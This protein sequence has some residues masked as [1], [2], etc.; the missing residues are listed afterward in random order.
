MFDKTTKYFTA[1]VKEMCTDF[2]NEL[3]TEDKNK[4][5]AFRHDGPYLATKK[6]GKH[7]P[8]EAEIKADN[9][10]RQEWNHAVDEA[11]TAGLPEEKIC[12]VKKDCIQ[13][14]IHESIEKT[15]FH[16]DFLSEIIQVAIRVPLDL[17]WGIPKKVH[18]KPVFDAEIFRRMQGVRKDL[19]HQ[20]QVI[21]AASRRCERA[22]AFSAEASRPGNIFKTQY[23][24]KGDKG[25]VGFSSGIRESD[26]R[27]GQ[28]RKTCWI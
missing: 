24:D 11:L 5:V 25:I 10:K 26:R 23:E 2:I 18:K 17:I 19:Q 6:I 1:G 27:T 7:N 22:Q 3:V 13:K 12:Q 20:N 21:A 28:D 8:K 15:G 14:P 9:A 4:L 16:P